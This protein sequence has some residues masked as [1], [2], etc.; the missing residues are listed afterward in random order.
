[1]NAIYF[2]NLQEISLFFCKKTPS[3]NIL[4][5]LKYSQ[6]IFKR[7]INAIKRVFSYIYIQY[8]IVKLCYILLYINKLNVKIKHFLQAFNKRLKI[9]QHICI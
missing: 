2:I 6:K 7:L 1:M 8:R 3:F 4:R 9:V 5:V